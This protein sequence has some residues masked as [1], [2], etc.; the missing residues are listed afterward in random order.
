MFGVLCDVLQPLIY[1][2]STELNDPLAYPKTNF[3][4]RLAKPRKRSRTQR[5]NLPVLG[6]LSCWRSGTYAE[7]RWTSTNEAA[8]RFRCPG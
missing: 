6:F 1:Y 2:T 3:D 8:R 5:V 7:L 4:G